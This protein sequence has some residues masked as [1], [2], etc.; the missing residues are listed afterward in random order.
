MNGA[1]C[2]TQSVE[3][4]QI[5]DWPAYS[6]ST[7]TTSGTQQQLV[8]ASLSPADTTGAERVAAFL[9][10]YNG[11]N[12]GQRL[13]APLGTATTKERFAMVQVHGVPHVITDIGMRMLHW[14]ELAAAQGLPA[15]YRWTGPDGE[16]LGKT[17][18]IR[19]IGNSV[20]PPPATALLRSVLGIAHT[21]RGLAA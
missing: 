16:H 19:L 14:R 6:V 11:T 8:T 7:I 9:L 4:R 21:E 13:D 1:E 18:I 12:I 5:N 17:K 10:R 2:T 20:S 3:W 15:D